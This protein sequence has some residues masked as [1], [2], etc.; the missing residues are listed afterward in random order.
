MKNSSLFL[1]KRVTFASLF[2][3]ECSLALLREFLRSKAKRQVE[4]QKSPFI[5]ARK[6]DKLVFLPPMLVVPPALSLHVQKRLRV[7][8]S[9][10]ACEANGLRQHAA[11]T[12]I[13]V[14]GFFDFGEPLSVSCGRGCSENSRV[15]H[16]SNRAIGKWWVIRLLIYRDGSLIFPVI[17]NTRGKNI[18]VSRQ[19]RGDLHY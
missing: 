1:R 13:D 8:S 19:S 15:C 2:R 7:L 6:S 17:F 18:Y 5:K 4:V 3:P 16:M 12:S 14:G 9:L 10:T 11:L